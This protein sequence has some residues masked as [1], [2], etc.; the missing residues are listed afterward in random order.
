M[1][2]AALV[3]PPAVRRAIVAHARRDRPREACGF[4]LGRGRRVSFAVPMTNLA[5]GNTRY[6]IDDQAHLDLRRAVRAFV[7][8]VSIV[9]AYHSHPNGPDAPSPRDV[10]ESMYAEWTH[11]IVS[12]RRPRAR[13]RAF[14]IV[15][16]RVFSVGLRPRGKTV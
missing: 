14:R 12:L 4:L 1:T 11:V 5:A 2:R 8:A 13:V 10:A 6:R 3:L 9:G 16:G 15:R 7:P